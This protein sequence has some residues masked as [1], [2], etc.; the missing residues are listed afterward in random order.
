MAVLGWIF[1][2]DIVVD[3]CKCIIY[4]LGIIPLFFSVVFAVLTQYFNYYGYLLQANKEVGQYQGN[5][6]IIFNRADKCS[7]VTLILFLIGI[8]TVFIYYSMHFYRR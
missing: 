8:I 2:S 4:I 6:N 5:P 3:I 7:S 1:K